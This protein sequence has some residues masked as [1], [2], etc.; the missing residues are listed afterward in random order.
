MVDLAV[1]PNLYAPEWMGFTPPV[2]GVSDIETD[3]MLPISI[4]SGATLSGSNALQLAIGADAD[5]LLREIRFLF[6]LPLGGSILTDLR[7]RLRDGDGNLVTSDYI[8]AADLAGSVGPV[9]GFRKGSVLLFEFQNVG[10]GT[11]NAQLIFKCIKRVPGPAVKVLPSPYTPLY[12]QYSTAP[13]GFHD[14]AYSYYYEIPLTTALPAL[15]FPLQ[16]DND[17][18]FLWR[19]SAGDGSALFANVTLYT[20]SDLALQ[21]RQTVGIELPVTPYVS[22]FPR[23]WGAIPP[24]A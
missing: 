16:T 20:P 6:T 3:L 5:V 1:W 22:H 14:E 24:V 12:R 11:I 8:Y 7:V 15:H 23:P 2:S 4:A 13:P 9:L 18:P 10:V 21:S 19:A 17:A